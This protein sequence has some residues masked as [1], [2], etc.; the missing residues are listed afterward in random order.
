MPTSSYWV[1]F[2]DARGRK[3][4]RGGQLNYLGNDVSRSQILIDRLR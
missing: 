1:W 3:Y 4:Q 2:N